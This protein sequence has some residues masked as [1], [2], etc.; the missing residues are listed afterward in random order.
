MDV[1]GFQSLIPRRLQPNQETRRV[2]IKSWQS[3]VL[4]YCRHHRRYVLDVRSVGDEELFRNK[5]INR[6]W[7]VEEGGCRMEV[8]CAGSLGTKTIRTVLESLNELGNIEWLDKEHN[9]CFVLWKS[10]D[11]WANLVYKWVRAEFGLISC[12]ISCFQFSGMR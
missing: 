5:A 9:R 10:V 12:L 6:E 2:Q 11:E 1:R 3:L 7:W 4:D 8:V